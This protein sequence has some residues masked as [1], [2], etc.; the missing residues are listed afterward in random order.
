MFSVV[1]SLFVAFAVPHRGAVPPP[2]PTRSVAS[3][4][5][6][7][8]PSSWAQSSWAQSTW[9]RP[10]AG[11]VIVPFRAPSGPYGAGH[12]GVDL[13]A[14]PGTEVRAAA[15]GVVVVAGWVAGTQHVVIA[16]AGGRR[17]GYSFLASVI[18]RTGDRV[19]TGALLGTTGGQGP[20]GDRRHRGAVLHWSLRVG[21]VYVDPMTVLAPPDLARSVH[22]APPGRRPVGRGRG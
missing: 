8:A 10:V 1:F 15:G 13:A 12:R 7:W 20:S 5:S 6:S 16:H 14:A 3:A 2:P 18:V 17:T 4:P 22:L 9:V 19:R 11:R 21:S